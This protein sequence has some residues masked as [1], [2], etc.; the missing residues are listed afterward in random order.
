MSAPEI[1]REGGDALTIA[2]GDAGSELYGVA[3]LGV[4][5]VAEPAQASGLLLLFHRGDTA[6]VAADGAVALT[7]RPTSWDDVSAAG[8]DITAGDGGWTLQW[9]GEEGALDL[10][11][12]PLGA[13][14]EL[15]EGT[16]QALRVTGTA[17]IGAT[18][19]K[20]DALG[21][22]GRS[23]A[24][25]DWERTEL[26][27]S[28]QVWLGKR[29]VTAQAVRAAGATHG[30][31]RLD[32]VIL[33]RGDEPVAV[34][35]P[36]PRLSTTYDGEGRQRHAGL[37]LWLGEDGPVHRFAGEAV[38]GTTLDLGRLRLD[39]AFFVWRGGGDEGVGRYDV[40]RRVG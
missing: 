22:R 8:I 1:R 31:E 27:R 14:A 35:V 21:Q 39:T 33:E 23:W 20:V 40:L 12:E 30:D 2:F 34:P 9:A 16:E 13:V 19:I 10:R 25:P 18:R 11:L 24:A 28:V 37:E 6:A 17:S 36:D 4:S 38:A 7:G 32:V 15:P 3:R 5:D 29:A 26:A